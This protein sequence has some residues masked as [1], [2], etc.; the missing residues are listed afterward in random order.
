[1]IVRLKV[2]IYG[3]TGTK[4]CKFQFY[5]SP[6]KSC[7]FQHIRIDSNGFQFYDSPIK[8]SCLENKSGMRMEF[9]FYD[10]PIKR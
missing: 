6:I 9:Q 5:D 3:V 8:S 4:E 7:Y 2:T 1:M 10:S